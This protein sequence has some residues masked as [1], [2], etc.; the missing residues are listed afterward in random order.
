MSQVLFTFSSSHAAMEAELTV[1]GEGLAARLIPLPSTISAGC[2]L[3]LLANSALK[4]HIHAL[5][6]QHHIPFEAVYI[7]TEERWE[8][9]QT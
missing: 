3:A 9:Q 6:G 7:K 1:E 8:K 2:G 4:R 5:L